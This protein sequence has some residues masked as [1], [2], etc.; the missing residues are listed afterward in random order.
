MRRLK[1]EGVEVVIYDPMI[2]EKEFARS[3]VI[4]DFQKFKDM[5]DV[6]VANRY[7]HELDDV[8]GKV[9]TRDIFYRD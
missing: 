8:K 7:D 1:G 9:Y 5:S 2:K 3:K 6:I 4:D